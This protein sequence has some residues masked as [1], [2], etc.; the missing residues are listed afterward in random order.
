M[1]NFTVGALQV[2]MLVWV[3]PALVTFDFYNSGLMLA[4]EHGNFLLFLFV[5]LAV[6]LIGG[7]INNGWRSNDSRCK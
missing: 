6:P 3:L 7:L 5:L 1:N 2:V 4:L